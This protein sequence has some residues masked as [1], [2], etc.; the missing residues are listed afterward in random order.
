MRLA[1]ESASCFGLQGSDVVDEAWPRTH[2]H[3]LL[4]LSRPLFWVWLYGLRFHAS[5]IGLRTQTKWL[6]RVAH[7]GLQA[8]EEGKQPE[9]EEDD[10]ASVVTPLGI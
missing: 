9:E 1:A 4:S 10:E 7:P 5:F 8:C 2:S 3:P 6:Y